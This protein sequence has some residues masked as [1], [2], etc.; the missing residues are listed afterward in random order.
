MDA[1]TPNS[2]LASNKSISR[3]NFL[4][5]A[6]GAAAYL[7]TRQNAEATGT[8]A[9][10]DSVETF[11]SD[12]TF[13]NIPTPGNVINPYTVTGNAYFGSGYPWIDVKAYGAVGDGSI[14]DT[15]A[16]NSAIAAAIPNT[17]G[18]SAGGGTA[19][20]GTDGT[21]NKMV[22]F[23]PGNYKITSSILPPNSASNYSLIG[24]GRWSSQI[25]WY[26]SAGSSMLKLINARGVTIRGLGFFGNAR[27]TPA[28]GIEINRTAGMVGSSNPTEIVVENCYLGSLAD[29]AM[30][31]AIG[32]TADSSTYDN[33]PS[34]FGTFRDVYIAN[35]ATAYHFGTTQAYGNNIVIGEVESSTSAAFDNTAAPYKVSGTSAYGGSYS[36]F[37]TRTSG[38]A[39]VF[40]IGQS[41]GYSINVYS[42]QGESDDQII[43][44]PSAIGA[45]TVQFFGGLIGGG[46]PSPNSMLFNSTGGQIEFHGFE[47]YVG[48]PVNAPLGVW[49]FQGSAA[50]AFYGG[51]LW[52]Q[53]WL[54]NGP[55]QLHGMYE[56][57]NDTGT[58]FSNQGSGILQE[59]NHDGHLVGSAVGING[60]V[61]HSTAGTAAGSGA[62][63]TVKGS[64]VAGVI[65][66]TTGSGMAAGTL[67]TINYGIAFPAHNS[68]GGTLPPPIVLIMSSEPNSAAAL[69]KSY[70]TNNTASS[71]TLAAT[72]ALTSS[73]GTVYQWSYLVMG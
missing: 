14:D 46:T 17:G 63:V 20:V 73:P 2:N 4:L 60:N 71:F 38:N 62:S 6:T 12:Q 55:L 52:S 34:G 10:L 23:P 58:A 70:A 65:T 37:G 16:I 48:G 64:D 50:V 28:Y 39:V 72:A 47:C 56:G 26:G 69:T 21:G 9:Y 24:A 29:N 22:Y 5:A 27:G 33:I 68:S 42:I 67:V 8:Q 30:G 36:L 61:S 40:N 44:T 18:G 57:G 45:Q 66:L 15:G 19:T 31:T 13:G 25:I 41:N 54:F 53:Q 1:E 35:V 32:Y 7:G 43:S 49:N 11:S 59:Y 51:F 3:K